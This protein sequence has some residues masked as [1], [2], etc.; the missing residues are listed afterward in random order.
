MEERFFKFSLFS[1][2]PE[3]VQGIT[4]RSY[5]DMTFSHLPLEE[6]VKNR[7][8]FATDLG[9]D[10]NQVVSPQLV[11]GN[12][13]VVVGVGDKGKGALSPES[14]LPGVDGMITKERGL[15]LMTTVADCIPV[16]VYDPA[17]RVVALI[18]AGWRGIIDQ[19]IPKTIDKFRDFN[20]KPEDL[21]VG[22]GP[23]ICQKHFIVKNSVLKLFLENYPSATLV[24][25][26]D[27]YVDL[28]KAILGDFKKAHVHAGN[29]E[30]SH[31]CTV[32][33][34]GVYG[35][36]RKEGEKGP[37]MAAIIGLRQ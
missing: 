25:N 29:I 14:R 23:G 27:G 19:I 30:I 11:H 1:C 5:G 28:K 26:K 17:N 9:I 6:V 2:F 32:C 24:R 4:N 15:F 31:A 33:D 7:R 20:S 12:R 35:S 18:H 22:I 37:K 36:Y 16:F 8:Q 13:I 34:N 10:L 3:I 21:I